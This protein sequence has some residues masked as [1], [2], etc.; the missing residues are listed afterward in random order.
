MSLPTMEEIRE[1]AGDQPVTDDLRYGVES[2]RFEWTV[3]ARKGEGK[4]VKEAV[5][6]VRRL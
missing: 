1:A 5:E 2:G 3:W 6:F 4:G